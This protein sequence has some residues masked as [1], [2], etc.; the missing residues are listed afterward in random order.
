MWRP[1]DQG[2]VCDVRNCSMRGLP[3]LRSGLTGVISH[4]RRSPTTAYFQKCHSMPDPGKT[5]LSVERPNL[6]G[7]F[8]WRSGTGTIG[9]YAS[10]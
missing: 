3:V 5:H 9:D 7:D 10:V 8:V 4:N 2:V 1:G 6:C